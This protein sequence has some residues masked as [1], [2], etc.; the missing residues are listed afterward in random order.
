MPVVAVAYHVLFA[1]GDDWTS[2]MKWATTWDCGD[3]GTY[4][5]E[6]WYDPD[7]EILA[8]GLHRRRRQAGRHRRPAADDDQR[9]HRVSGYNAVSG[10]EVGYFDQLYFPIVQTNC[11]PG[12]CWDSVLRVAN[13]GAGCQRRRNRTVLPVR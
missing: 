6:Y 1:V 2:K 9:R 12:G 11:G 13:V 3:Y 4:P 5:G 8:P 7:V 10:R